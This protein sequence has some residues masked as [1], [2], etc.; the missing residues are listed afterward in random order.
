MKLEILTREDLKQVT[1][2]ASRALEYDHVSIDLI[3]EKCFGD[4]SYLPQ[5][6]WVMKDEQKVLGF[7][8]G[9]FRDYYKGKTGW[10]KMM[11]VDPDFRRNNI[12]TELVKTL[13]VELKK[14][15]ATEFK[16]MDVPL[17][18]F[19]PGLDPR[20]TEGIVFLQKLGFEKTGEH[21]NMNVDLEDMDF[22]TVDE[23]KKLGEEG[24]IIKR[25]APDE[26]E[27]VIKFTDP[28]WEMWNYEVNQ[29]FKNEPISLHIAI[30]N[31]S[32]VAFSAYNGN[33]VGLPWFG[34]MG[35]HPD[36]RGKRLGEIL[37]KRC[38]QDQKNMGFHY[39][40]IPWV[41]P[42]GFYLKAVDAHISRVFWTFKKALI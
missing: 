7:V 24:I 14:L 19:M 28:I 34:P 16:V 27:A 35:T 10:I 5:L 37:L 6:N 32:V 26:K 9:A 40:I 31:G 42:I 38:L 4:P 23:E 17:N 18:Y 21:I 36:M 13:E 8:I 33:N 20:Y 11:A 3:E 12:G 22:S 29:T 30:L 1:E 2:L 41:G 15:G 39:S 25:A